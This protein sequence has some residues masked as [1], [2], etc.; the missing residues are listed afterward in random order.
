M[1]AATLEDGHRHVD[2]Q[3][4]DAVIFNQRTLVEIVVGI[5]V[6][7]ANMTEQQARDVARQARVLTA[8]VVSYNDVIF[9]SHDTE[10]HWAMLIAFG[11]QYWLRGIS[12]EPPP[13]YDDWEADF[14]AKHQLAVASFVFS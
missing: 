12:S 13:G 8:P 1:I 4:G 5:L 6:R 3:S 14:I 10:F 7:W 2:E 11:E 9:L